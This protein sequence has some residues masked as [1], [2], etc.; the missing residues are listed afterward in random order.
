LEATVK[1]PAGSVGM[2]RVTEESGFVSRTIARRQESLYSHAVIALGNGK[3]LD[4]PWKWTR[5]RSQADW[6]ADRRVDWWEPRRAFTVDEV[7]QL[8]SLARFI[9]GRV[10][11][12]WRSIIRWV[13]RGRGSPNRSHGLFC[14]QLVAEVYLTIRDVD[15]SGA[16]QPWNVDLRMLYAALQDSRDFVE[17]PSLVPWSDR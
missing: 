11:Y 2:T 1:A 12:S 16:E 3:V 14:S 9:E 15:F 10:A 6:E 7:R 5:V 8:R 13:V 4:Q 17:W